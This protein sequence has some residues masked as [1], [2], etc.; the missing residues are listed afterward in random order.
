MRLDGDFE[1]ALAAAVLGDVEPAFIDRVESAV[2]RS[3][4]IL[5]EAAREHDYRVD[6]VIE[7]LGGPEIERTDRG[8][9]ARWGWDHEAAPYFEFGTSDHTVEGDPVLSFVWEE[10]HDPPDWVRVEFDREGDGYRVFLHEVEVSGVAETR[11]IRDALA[12][13]RRE[14]SA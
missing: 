2:Q 13:L 3:H 10:R 4:D 7:S 6:G 8:L 14:L 5:E 9:R 1:D 11:F 12:W